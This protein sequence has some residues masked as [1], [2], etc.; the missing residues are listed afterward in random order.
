MPTTKSPAPPTVSTIPA[1]DEGSPVLSCNE[2]I[3]LEPGSRLL[4]AALDCT[5]P[6]SILVFEVTGDPDE[7]F[8]AYAQQIGA[9]KGFNPPVKEDVSSE[10]DGRTVREAGIFADDSSYLRLTMLSGDDRP[11]VMSIQQVSG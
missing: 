1:P 10:F 6:T 11:T 3:T 9:A 4:G 7:V 8:A 5:W 2:A